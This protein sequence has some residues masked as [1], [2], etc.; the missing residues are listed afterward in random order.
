MSTNLTTLYQYVMPELPGC[1]SAL[2]D[3]EIIEVVKDFCER[4]LQ[5][6]TPSD[7]PVKINI[8]DEQKQYDVDCPDTQAEVVTYKKVLRRYYD[9][10]E[11][12]DLQELYPEKDYTRPEHN[13]IKLDAEPTAD[14]TNG[15]EISLALRPRRTCTKVPDCLFDQFYMVWANGVMGR[16]MKMEGKRWSNPVR[17]AELSEKY[18]A[19]VVAAMTDERR[20]HTLKR[21]QA[22]PRWKFA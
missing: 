8:K 2:I 9:A 19:G 14:Q 13:L 7:D 10:E 12:D 4:T 6:D 11:T 17:G 18:E 21:L 15:L 3:R 22:K 5:W 1:P 20:G 16:L